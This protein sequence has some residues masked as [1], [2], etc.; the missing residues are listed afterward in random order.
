MLE[1]DRQA[2]GAVVGALRRHVHHVLDAVDLLLDRRGHGLGD[3]LGAGA[4]ILAVTDTFGG[5]IGG[6]IAIGSATSDKP[7]GQRDDDRQ[8]RGEDR[9]IDEEARK[10][11]GV[12]LQFSRSAG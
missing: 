3:H 1:G 7:A 8:H 9:A 2:V 11:G 4:G 5:E 12:S 6:Y 10:H